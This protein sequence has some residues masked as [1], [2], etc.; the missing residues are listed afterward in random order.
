MLGHSSS[1][2]TA[3]T[4]TSLLPETDLAI[5]EAAA[6]PV[7]RARTMPKDAG[8]GADVQ[9][10][11]TEGSVPDDADP[12]GV[13]REINFPSAHT[14]GPGPEVRGR[15]RPLPGGE[16]PGQS[17]DALCPRQDSNLRHPL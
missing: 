1:N 7:Q 11:E 12:L 10:S 6:R 14:N 13:I 3:D 16:A 4:Y 5:A 17:S 9:P 15:V 2:I 8:L